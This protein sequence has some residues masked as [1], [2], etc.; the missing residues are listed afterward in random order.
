MASKI[1]IF[2]CYAHEDEPLLNKLKHHLEALRRQGL[3][4][5]WYDRNISAGAE[6]AK[7]IDKHVNT[8]Q[9]ILL[10]VSQY[11]MASD[12][13][14]SVEMKRAMERHERGE[15]QVIPIILRP[16]YFQRAPFG[17]L[18]ALPTDAK[19]VKSKSWPNQDVAFFNVAEGIRKAVEEHQ[20]KGGKANQLVTDFLSKH[21]LMQD[22]D[23]LLSDIQENI[24]REEKLL[25]EN[26]SLIGIV[27]DNYNL[28]AQK[29]GDHVP[30]SFNRSV[31]FRIEL[32][33]DNFANAKYCQ[34]YHIEA[35]K[36]YLLLKGVSLEEVRTKAEQL[37]QTLKGEYSIEVNNPNW[38]RSLSPKVLITLYNITVHIGITWYTY[39]KLAEILNWDAIKGS[40]EKARNVIISDLDIACKHGINEGG[41]VIVSWDTQSWKYIRLPH[42]NTLE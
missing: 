37:R 2:F 33:L 3:I 1:E 6:W 16:V 34:F 19:P 36:F 15:A 12:Y 5:V 28:I 38:T 31:G 42:L 24:E 32:Q 29:Y 41:D 11:F 22:V 35:D 39:R 30:G 26:V 4:D 13:C 23:A 7:E 14:Y 40:I 18:Q 10:L 21:E 8:A 27:I 25:Y 20:M 9:I 17:K